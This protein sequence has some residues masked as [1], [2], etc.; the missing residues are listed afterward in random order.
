M[1]LRGHGCPIICR[2]ISDNSDVSAMRDTYKIGGIDENG[3]LDSFICEKC[4]RRHES[5]QC[6]DNPLRDDDV[7]AWGYDGDCD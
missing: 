5:C 3:R 1:I 6:E 7:R 2:G 4:G